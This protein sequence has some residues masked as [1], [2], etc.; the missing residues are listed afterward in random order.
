MVEGKRYEMLFVICYTLY[1]MRKKISLQL[2]FL[3]SLASDFL[4][5]PAAS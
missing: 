4:L 3:W 2:T 1:V 5:L